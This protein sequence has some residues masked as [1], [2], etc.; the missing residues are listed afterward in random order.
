LKLLL[1]DRELALRMGEEARNR[2][3]DLFTSQAYKEG[4]RRLFTAALKVVGEGR[5]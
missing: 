2:V 1:G 3:E 5:P 4:Y